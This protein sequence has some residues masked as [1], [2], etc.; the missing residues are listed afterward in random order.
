MKKLLLL[1]CMFLTAFMSGCATQY[2]AVGPNWQA[3]Y[4]APDGGAAKVSIEA[5]KERFMV[6][7]KMG[8]SVESNKSGKLWLITVGPDDAKRLVFP[9]R[10]ATDNSIEAGKAV[11]LPGELESWNLRAA[12]PL[13]QN[14]VVAIVTG[15]D[16]RQE[17]VGEL[18]MSPDFTKA[19]ALN[20]EPL[21]YGLAKMVVS[22][23]R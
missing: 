3:L 8:F 19:I 7:E 22:V 10:Y 21:K 11:Q 20:R 16:A 6:G 9:N 12:E 18:L 14:L 23:A 1:M 17:D 4:N 13:G 15:R 2:V 5:T